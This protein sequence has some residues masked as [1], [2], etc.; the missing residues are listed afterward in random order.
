[1]LFTEK[2]QL[3]LSSTQPLKDFVRDANSERIK[4]LLDNRVGVIAAMALLSLHL[5]M[6]IF[7]PNNHNSSGS[8]FTFIKLILGGLAVM[9][10]GNMLLKSKLKE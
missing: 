9:V 4:T 6:D 5:S 2:P 3:T 7:I 1:L 8:Y 10:L